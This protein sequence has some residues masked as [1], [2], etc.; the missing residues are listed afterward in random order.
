MAAIRRR[1]PLILA[2]HGIG[3]LPQEL[4]P[5]N[6]MVS[7]EDF[8]NQIRSVQGRGYEFLKMS[9][10]ARRLEDGGAP[11]ATCAITF[12]DGSEDVHAVL[13]G[14][15]EELGVPA[16]L[17][18]C[19]G[20]LGAQHF[21][22]EPGAGVRLVN[23]EELRELAAM[24]LIELGS[25]TNG[26]VDLSEADGE[27]A[28]AE[29]A[30]SKATLEELIGAEVTSFAYPYCTYS[31]ECPDAARRAGYTNA[32]TCGARGSWDPFELR[33]ESIN[34]LD[35]RGLFA[36]KSRGIF[37]AVRH[38]LPG[39]ALRAATRRIRNPQHHSPD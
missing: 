5:H 31:P 16:T 25:H 1:P 39:R 29:M 18:V 20:L 22:L 24:E 28:Y 30:A 12:D 33:R 37:W 21:D 6:L 14:L 15:L 7:A 35:G 27:R 34:A 4:D 38:S 9:E 23:G 2:Y 13:P 26:H 11:D 19:P 3:S 32:V 8:R 17:Y 10:F 36:L